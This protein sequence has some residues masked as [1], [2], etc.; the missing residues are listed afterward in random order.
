M[1]AFIVFDLI[2]GGEWGV[3]RGTRYH[4]QLLVMLALVLVLALTLAAP[5][6]LPRSE[7]KLYDTTRQASLI[8]SR[9]L[10]VSEADSVDDG[11]TR[12]RRGQGESE[13]SRP[14]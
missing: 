12:D 4:L 8:D 9:I 2:A 3:D 11:M 14:A 13:K 5:S 6:R 10:K 7:L 1:P